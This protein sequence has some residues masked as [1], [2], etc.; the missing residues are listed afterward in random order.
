[1]KPMIKYRGGKS[2]EIPNIMWH[3]PRFSGRYIE[4]FFGGG[5]LFFYLEPRRAVI[6]DINTK[7]MIFY[8]GVRDDF[9]NLRRELDEIELLYEANRNDFEILKASHPEERIVDKNELLYYRLRAM[10]NDCIEK[11]YSDALLYY[12][13]NKTAYSGMIRYNAKGE[14]NVPFGRYMHLNTKS[15]TLS[16][17]KLLQRAEIFN[18]DYSEVFNMCKDDDFVF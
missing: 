6:N 8:Q 10:F 5:A 7:L 1:M 2:R 4:P 18:T 17:S 14:F 13:I 9:S 16:H 12:Y 11:T 3:V 15:V